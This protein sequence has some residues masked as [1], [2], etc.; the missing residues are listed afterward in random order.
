[1]GVRRGADFDARKG[2]PFSLL[3]RSLEEN[4]DKLPGTNDAGQFAG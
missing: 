4:V 1:M 3:L 2:P